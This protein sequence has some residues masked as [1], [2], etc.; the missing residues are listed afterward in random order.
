[1]DIKNLAVQIMALK[2]KAEMADK[3]GNT[4]LRN[5]LLEQMRVL[6]DEAESSSK[7]PSR[8]VLV[9]SVYSM[10]NQMYFES[11][12]KKATSY[13]FDG[14]YRA[15][16][17]SEYP[18]SEE[19]MTM[20]LGSVMSLL[21][22]LI[23]VYNEKQNSEYRRILCEIAD[24]FKAVWDKLIA[25]NPSSMAALRGQ[26]IIQILRQANMLGQSNRT[27][28]DIKDN[29]IIATHMDYDNI[30]FQDMFTSIIKSYY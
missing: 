12:L 6:A 14:L 18:H 27:F 10:L 7:D 2:T 28:K 15:S 11:D 9:T 4:K 29:V 30:G 16:G 23:K 5:D 24:M 13:A 25:L 21:N 19:A 1:M 3:Q 26:K 20:L 17:L 22:C 8:F